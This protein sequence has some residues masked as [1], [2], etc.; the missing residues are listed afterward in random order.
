MLKL[1]SYDNNKLIINDPFSELWSIM[2][3]RGKYIQ[4]PEQIEKVVKQLPSKVVIKG[5]LRKDNKFYF[6]NINNDIIINSINNE[7]QL[8]I[9]Y[10]YEIEWMINSNCVCKN[11]NKNKINIGFYSPCRKFSVDR[12]YLNFD[13]NQN[14]LTK[15]E[16]HTGKILIN[17]HILQLFDYLLSS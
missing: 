11:K 6:D 3:F 14:K 16:C 2:K 10:E 12:L 5:K 13:K 17:C 8:S 1:Y 7:I 9:D 15:Y 4:F